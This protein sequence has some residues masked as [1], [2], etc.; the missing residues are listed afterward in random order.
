[1]VRQ[2]GQESRPINRVHETAFMNRFQVYS[3]I[4]IVS[5]P[6]T[7][8]AWEEYAPFTSGADVAAACA[9]VVGAAGL[10]GVTPDEGE[11]EQGMVQ[12]SDAPCAPHHRDS[13]QWAPTEYHFR[14]VPGRAVVAP[15]AVRRLRAPSRCNR[16]CYSPGLQPLGEQPCNRPASAGRD[17]LVRPVA[18]RLDA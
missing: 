3:V 11:C 12:A 17:P 9:T 18:N 6:L 16:G 8:S 2:M 7:S 10:A 15:D 5:I 14:P 13:R 1:M 4:F